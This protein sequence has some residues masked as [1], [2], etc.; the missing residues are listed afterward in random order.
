MTAAALDKENRENS[1]PG[2]QPFVKDLTE[3]VKRF[4]SHREAREAPAQPAAGQQARHRPREAP[5]APRKESKADAL[6]R[7]AMRGVMASPTPTKARREQA[8]ARAEADTASSPAPAK[9]RARGQGQHARDGEAQEDGAELSARARRLWQELQER[10]AE[11][12]G[13]PAKPSR[14]RPKGARSGASDVAHD[15]STKTPGKTSRMRPAPRDQAQDDAHMADPA[16]AQH[17][18]PPSPGRSRQRATH[19]QPLPAWAA[20][21]DQDKAIAVSAPDAER[22]PRLRAALKAAVADHEKSASRAA[23]LEEECHIQQTLLRSALK[24][25]ADLT[26]QL[27]RARREQSTAAADASSSRAAATE[28]EKACRSAR[29]AL[30][31]C[32]SQNAK[33]V[34]AYAEKKKEAKELGA[35]VQRNRGT[36]AEQAKGAE[37]ELATVH[38]ELRAAKAEAEA[39][40]ERAIRAEVR[41]E[42]SEAAAAGA[43]KQQAQQQ[44]QQQPAASAATTESEAAHTAP[45]PSAS[46]SSAEPSVSRGSTA[47]GA[48]PSQ[49]TGSRR[50]N[51]S[52][53]EEAHWAEEKARWAKEKDRW[54]AE[55]QR[56][57]NE[58]ESTR[59][60][61]RGGAAPPGGEGGK[62]ER[63]ARRRASVSSGG[64]DSSC[65]STGIAN[66][67]ESRQHA[68]PQPAADAETDVNSGSTAA[69]KA[70]APVPETVVPESAAP[71]QQQERP[72]SAAVLPAETAAAAAQTPSKRRPTSAPGRS[73][74]LRPSPSARRAREA[75]VAGERERKE[76][77]AEAAAAA[78]KEHK[79][80]EDTASALS[81][82]QAHKA[83]GNSAY[84][85]GNYKDAYAEYTKGIERN[86]S[87]RSFQAILH[88]NRA[89]AL[90]AQK[91]YVHAA[92]DCNAALSL[93]TR[94]SR[95]LQRRV[96]VWTAMGDYNQAIRDLQALIAPPHRLG[97]EASTKLADAQRRARHSKGADPYVVLSVG[98]TASAAEV[99]K[100]YRKLALQFHP[101]KCRDEKLRP[102]TE[103]LFKMVSAAHNTL[104]DPAARRKHDQAAFASMARE[105][106][107]GYT[108]GASSRGHGSYASY[109][110]G[111]ASA[112]SN[113]ASG[114]YARARSRSF[115]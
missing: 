19:R 95:A 59:Q 113:F 89:A 26:A 103:V 74:K 32:A 9:Q 21:L 72:T 22:A 50:S 93:D 78:R 94:Y 96:D 65:A 1:A 86:C 63:E 67:A 17:A 12:G 88:C 61:I 5:A 46:H 6:R 47:K 97:A 64:D 24:R 68:M 77:E 90:M 55:K 75:F 70:A 14:V 11:G 99:K 69:P 82:A 110:R 87:D 106:S 83:A 81:K 91:Q 49:S 101:D 79:E 60:T 54:A 80:R 115:A 38:A 13:A 15:T 71:Q 20:V 8:Q 44:A 45:E 41:L 51:T 52:S 37:D 43:R 36:A 114:A 42:K 56:W 76:A 31:E 27:Q 57:M 102:Q 112:Y 34:A 66:G 29:Q 92:A 108:S 30:A 23:A 35:E 62:P 105:A 85:K 53:E 58:L 16:G 10:E 107:R 98:A 40:R 3:C 39:L 84:Q 100:A 48:S 33:L 7:R 18:V 104:S 109:G 73:P 111:G 25:Q 4:A 2:Q 28:A